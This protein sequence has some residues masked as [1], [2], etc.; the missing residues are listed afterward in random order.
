METLKRLY[1][2]MKSATIVCAITSLSSA[3]A[4]EISE[5]PA[6]AIGGVEPNVMLVL[7][8]SGS[9]G[10]ETV[11][12]TNDGIL[13]VNPNTGRFEGNGELLFNGP[14]ASSYRQVFS[15]PGVAALTTPPLDAYGFVFSAEYNGAYYDNNVTY[16][17]WP[18]YGCY[19]PNGDNEANNNNRNCPDAP[20]PNANP[21]AANIDPFSATAFNLTATRTGIDYT[22][23]P[24]MVCDNQGTV[25]TVVGG[26]MVCGPTP[27]QQ[28]IIDDIN[29]AIKAESYDPAFY[30]Q[31]VVGAGFNFVVGGQTFQCQ[32]DNLAHNFALAPNKAD[33]YFQAMRNP[34]LFLT[35]TIDALAPD[36]SCLKKTAVT[37][38]VNNY[39]YVVTNEDGVSQAAT[40]TYAEEIQNFANWF[41]YYRSRNHALRG[42]LGEGFRN[43]QNKEFNIGA[44]TI[45]Q[46]NNF[47][48][49]KDFNNNTATFLEYAYQVP[50]GGGTPLRTALDRAG[51]YYSTR[52]TGQLIT[53]RCQ[54]NYTILFT[55]GFNSD[56]AVS[57]IGNED[58]GK[59]EPFQ[60]GA[61]GTLA[62][63]AY[64]HYNDL[65]LAFANDPDLS[66]GGVQGDRACGTAEERPWHDCND[67]LH[68][69]TYTFGLNAKGN[70]YDPTNPNRDSVEDAHLFA[71]Q[72]AWPEADINTA[73]NAS[74]I[75]D[76]WHAAVNGKGE[77]TNAAS[78]AEIS[79]GIEAILDNVLSGDFANSGVDSTDGSIALAG[80]SAGQNARL[81]FQG[82]MNIS[83]A[84]GDLEAYALLDDGQISATPVWSAA[85]LLE[86]RNP[87]TRKI[88]T[89]NKDANNS[90]GEG[91]VFSWDNLSQDQR[92][93]LLVRT[94]NSVDI[95]QRRL[96][97]LRGFRN[98]ADGIILR[99]ADT[100]I[101]GDIASSTP[102]FYGA[103]NL[104]IDDFDPFG[105]DG[106]RYSNFV[107]D[108][109]DR[110][111]VVYVGANDG[112]LHA[113]RADSGEELFAYV[114]SLIAS[115]EENRGMNYLTDPDY[116]RR[117][118]VDLSPTIFDAFIK[119]PSDQI[120]KWRSVLIG[121][122]RTGGKGIF[123]LDVTDPMG[124]S[125]AENNNNAQ[126]LVM[127]EFSDGDN[128]GTLLDK[129]RIAMLNNGQWAVIFS[130]GYSQDGD[131]ELEGAL[132]IVYLE[133]DTPNQV[134][135]RKISTQTNAGLSGATL[136]DIDENGTV[137]RVYAGDLLGN[138]WAFDLSS[139]NDLDW[140]IENNAPLFSARQGQAITSPPV[141]TRNTYVASPLGGVNLLVGFGTG[142]YLAE[143]DIE[144]TT[145]QSFYLIYDRGQTGL[146]RTNLQQQTFDTNGNGVRTASG[147]APNWVQSMGWYFDYP[148]AGERTFLQ[149][150]V[151]LPFQTISFF[152]SVPSVDACINGGSSWFMTLKLDG[153]PADQNPFSN[154]P[155][156]DADDA[157]GISVG[158]TI[159]VSHDSISEVNG[160]TSSLIQLGR[161]SDQS[162]FAPQMEFTLDSNG[163]RLA[164]EELVDT[165]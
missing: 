126:Q 26:N 152:S 64:K 116:Q 127:W 72:F 146:T 118:Y 98:Q 131:A 73:R 38:T 33:L 13:R 124:I 153:Q 115:P 132:Y 57:G 110:Q 135:F 85:T 97:F 7:D 51:R 112:M 160:N 136:A 165:K 109:K 141:V 42:A 122:L 134:R 151:F 91:R 1:F 75:D 28:V 140:E 25:V 44:F 107:E 100:P 71:N 54:S 113:F 89:L 81:I 47:E 161:G 68:M 29:L 121:G 96:N 5:T 78:T 69:T 36:G 143:S 4:V 24:G 155:G 27:M 123:A 46:Q 55:D 35:P 82:K 34:D 21:I 65:H 66:R 8:D 41:T 39:P 148:L 157:A 95:A 139:A 31:K 154:L 164:W 19:E 145:L 2:G 101:L 56:G 37:P 144:D 117:G 104:N 108:N 18:V 49:L 103:P 158:N 17:P 76:L 3:H 163:Q 105:A 111:G 58:G 130:N 138:M 6:F 22:Y 137:D 93:D 147:N 61:S 20:F 79:Q 150:T 30:F 80:S 15:I 12:P 45:N 60:D 67:K 77:I 90:N 86:N 114:P 23:S 32:A 128:I 84:S 106:A 125:A 102:I 142:K 53:H 156:F 159:I 62:D 14:F 92:N 70:L 129:P 120:A 74:Q 149:P 99:P 43:Q 40:R 83:E 87:N 94:N 59:G 10:F 162:N 63:V 16:V 9:M 88:Y 52:G 50:T 133:A 48:G 11:F 119:T